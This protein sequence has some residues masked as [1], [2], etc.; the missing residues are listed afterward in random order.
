MKRIIFQNVQI[1]LIIFSINSI[2]RELDEIGAAAGSA[3]SWAAGSAASWAAGSAAGSGGDSGA[4][5]GKL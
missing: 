5:S 4:A 1:I 3:A 2:R